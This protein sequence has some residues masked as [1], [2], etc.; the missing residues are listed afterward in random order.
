M[1]YTEQYNVIVNKISKSLY[2]EYVADEVITQAM[3]D[4]QVWIFTDDQYLSLANLNKLL[5]I[6][7]NAQVNVI[8]GIQVNGTSLTPSEKVVNIVMP[9]K[10]SDLTN[11]SNF[12]DNT[13]SNL[14]NYYTKNEVNNLISGI[15][16]LSM[17]LVSALP[18]SD[19][20]TTTIYL[21]LK[22][23]G[24]SGNI[25]NEYIY[26]NGSWE[27]IGDTQLDLSNYALTSDIPTKLSD[28]TNDLDLSAYENV[29]ETVKVNGVEVTPVG[30]VVDITLPTNT[31]EA[32]VINTVKVN[33]I[34][35]TPDENK[36][37]DIS[38]PIAKTRIWS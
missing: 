20:S 27:L 31:G 7:A 4:E 1:P 3:I 17:Q 18:T 23:V 16:A 14:V 5:G 24:L 30:K 6:E 22:A 9:T 29:I 33:G 36:A 8:E 19:I 21:V 34:A 2:D 35:L 25:Y 32:N 38:V 26:V 13:V 10:T 12:I 28:L 15:S 37:V 11:D